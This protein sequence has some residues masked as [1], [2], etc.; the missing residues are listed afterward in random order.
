MYFDFDSMM[1]F[2]RR[3]NI[4]NQHDFAMIN[5]GVV[6]DTPSFLAKIVNPKIHLGRLNYGD[7]IRICSVILG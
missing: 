4:F 7:Y 6:Y 5:S 1:T 3:R 2:Y